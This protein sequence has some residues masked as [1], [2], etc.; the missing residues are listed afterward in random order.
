MWRELKTHK[1]YAVN[2][3]KRSECLCFNSNE[4]LPFVVYGIHAHTCTRLIIP[5]KCQ[6]HSTCEQLLVVLCRNETD[7][8]HMNRLEFLFVLNWN[9]LFRICFPTKSLT[10]KVNSNE[11]RIEFC[12]ERPNKKLSKISNCFY[13]LGWYRV[14]DILENSPIYRMRC[15]CACVCVGNAIRCKCVYIWKWQ[16]IMFCCFFFS[17]YFVCLNSCPLSMCAVSLSDKCVPLYAVYIFIRT[18]RCTFISFHFIV[19]SLFTVQT[20]P[21]I[22]RFFLPQMYLTVQK[23]FSL[24]RWVNVLVII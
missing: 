14:F 17:F 3:F 22:S 19:V 5:V 13:S 12:A 9:H 4:R 7:S 18:S 20:V 24:F 11:F 21:S 8:N 1:S 6:C 2:D 10:G 23:N 16:W 15:V